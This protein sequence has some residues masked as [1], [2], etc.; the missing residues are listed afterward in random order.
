MKKLLIKQIV[1]SGLF[2]AIG[3]LLPFLTAQNPILGKKLLPMHLPVL[4]C[5]FVC[6]WP[7][8]LIVGFVLPVFRSMLFGM[9]PMFPTAVAMSFELAAYGCLTGLF[10]KLL[11]KK[12]AYIF[13]S[14]I[15]AMIGGRIVWGAVSYI[16]YGLSKSA[17]TW[18]LFIAGAFLD[19]IPGIVVQIIIIPVIVFALA[20]A[21]LIEDVK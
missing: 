4:L 19:A 1:L 8:G 6:G 3:L 13:V 18:Q 7:Y 10:Y 21:K 14:L 20:R 5:G 16:L 12:N 9:P 15:I 2:I 11:P 17:F